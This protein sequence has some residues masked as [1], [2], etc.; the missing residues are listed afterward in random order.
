MT[1]LVVCCAAFLVCSLA[2]AAQAQSGGFLVRLGSDTIAVERFERRGGKIEGTLVRRT[3]QTNLVRYTITLNADGS[4]AAYEQAIQRPDGSPAPN[5]PVPLTMTFA[6]DSVLRNVV[7][8][9]EPVTLR[10]AAPKGTV[11]SIGGSWLAY[12]L[13]IDAAKRADAAGPGA[14]VHTIGF[15]PQQAA[16]ARADVRFI[17]ADSAELVV[18]GF[19]TGFKLAG[20]GRITRG[21]GS[22]TTQ[23]FIVTPLAN[24]N[25]AAIASAWAA[26]DAAGQPMGSA[27]PRDTVNAAVGAATIMID[28]GRPAKRGREIWGKLVPFDTTWR[29][30]A[31]AATQFRTDKDLAIGGV[32]VPAGFYSL[33]L[34]PTADKT[35]LIVNTQT[36]QW[37][38]M[39][40]QS[41]DLV[42]I[43]VEAHMSLPEGEGEERFRIFVAGDMLMMHWD[44]GGY[45]VKIR[46]Q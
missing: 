1:R 23:K 27:S 8:N 37:G 4:V 25:V 28:Y 18:Q 46:A 35:W 20:D 12:E 15:N 26:K 42:R 16:P 38:T 32:T 3:P 33:W 11:P 13:L 17:G 19:R 7:R 21:D 45:G 40:D 43:P 44:K 24:P 34:Y 2:S 14:G 41:K 39:Y 6:G 31:N 22:L 9:N 5:A 30:G 10:S 36:G 29:L